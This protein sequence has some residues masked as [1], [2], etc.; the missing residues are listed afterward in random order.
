MSGSDS[1]EVVNEGT[2]SAAP[3]QG[4]CTG[5]GAINIGLACTNRSDNG[6]VLLTRSINHSINQPASI[7]ALS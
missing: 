5:I 7:S 4:A 3:S 2:E 6:L 1:E